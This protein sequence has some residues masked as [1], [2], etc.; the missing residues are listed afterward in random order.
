MACFPNYTNCSVVKT[1]ME[2]F[3]NHIPGSGTQCPG[4]LPVSFVIQSSLWKC[5][6]MPVLSTGTNVFS[7]K[8]IAGSDQDNLEETYHYQLTTTSQPRRSLI[9][10]N[11]SLICIVETSSEIYGQ[12]LKEW[13]ETY[14]N[15]LIQQDANLGSYQGT[16]FHASIVL[17]PV[18]SKNH[19][20][21]LCAGLGI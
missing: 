4:C 8:C 6:Y 15:L 1:T 21:I 7:F 18:S 17:L 16:L 2:I 5:F 9:V 19:L 3:Q 20:S 12:R 13:T 10:L 14:R 11:R